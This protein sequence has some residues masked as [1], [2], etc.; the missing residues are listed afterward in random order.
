MIYLVIENQLYL[1]YVTSHMNKD[2]FKYTILKENQ[3]LSNINY[4]KNSVIV[5]QSDSNEDYL[6]DVTKKIKRI[7]GLD[8]NIVF[9]SSDPE[10]ENDAKNSSDLFLP[11]PLM[12]DSLIDCIF[13][14]T[15]SLRK[16]LIID[17]SRLVHSQLVPPLKE[18]GYDVYE[19]FNGKEGVEI[20]SK[21]KPDLII[22][23]IEMPVMNGFDACKL[24]RSNPSIQDTYIIMSS[25]L[26]SASDIQKGFE[27]G[28]NEYITKPVIIEELLERI[29][30]V[31][32]QSISGRED[33]LIFIKDELFA[34]N[35]SKSL[36]KQGF[37]TKIVKT[38]KEC[39]KQIQ[40]S[41]YEL[42]II[43]SANHDEDLMEYI[44]KIKSKEIDKIPSILLLL[45]RD[46][47][48]DSRMALNIGVNSVLSKPFS[49]DNLLAIV[50]RVL[51]ERRANHEKKQMLKYMSRSSVKIAEEKAAFSGTSQQ[52]ARAIK[53]N[54]SIF[55]SDIVSF[56]NRC[57]RY[58]ASQVVEQI[59]QLFSVMTRIIQ[60]YGGDIDKFMGDACMAFW[61]SENK[62]Q[63][64]LNMVKAAVSIQNE[65]NE[66]NLNN[67]ILSKDPIQIRIGMNY[68][69]VI[70]CDIGSPDSRIDLTII[71]DSVN[72]AS[73][74]ESICKYYGVNYLVTE[75]IYTDISKEFTTRLIDKIQVQGKD[76]ITP[77][78]EILSGEKLN[79]TNFVELYQ[80]YTSGWNQYAEGNFQEAIPYFEKSI[81]L[82]PN[83][84]LNP[85]NKSPSLILLNRCKSLQISKPSQ[86]NGVWKFDSK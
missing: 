1:D 24:I 54:A 12:Y 70:L 10:V 84:I 62:Y 73:R 9:L 43:D 15:S 40:K 21:V 30:R 55:F 49:M 77:I 6:L 7:L 45:N 60:K 48:S 36:I 44:I 65:L 78:Y 61:M 63:D 14:I 2:S 39:D 28:V 26:S 38:T 71:G 46:N 32:K 56:T 17:D 3:I 22:C 86:W 85:E 76:N 16:I 57:E 83:Y 13:N 33:I 75:E 58:T 41:K 82:E 53:T 50:E 25:T 5:V 31:F 68:G 79:L 81:E 67:P 47:Q 4:L 72:L 64:N 37:S 42:L 11:M 69:E 18:N 35:I 34:S 52:S 66:L 74:L 19:A 29:S 23:D 20:A 8:V 59:N 51:A 80:L 27:A